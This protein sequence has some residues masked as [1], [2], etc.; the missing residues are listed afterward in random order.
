[1]KNHNKNLLFLLFAVLFMVSINSAIFYYTVCTGDSVKSVDCYGQ[2]Y[3]SEKSVN[4]QI[5]KIFEEYGNNYS[6]MKS[7]L[8]D[9]SN[10]LGDIGYYLRSIENN[11]ATLGE[12]R[13]N[14]NLSKER[15]EMLEKLISYFGDENINIESAKQTVSNRTSVLYLATANIDKYSDYNSFLATVSDNADFMLDISIYKNDLFAVNNIEKTKSDYALL[16]GLSPKYADDSGVSSFLN[17]RITDIIALLSIILLMPFFAGMIKSAGSTLTLDK[18]HALLLP[19]LLTGAVAVMQCA[20]LL[21]A[22]L[23]IG[24]IDF[25]L[26]IQSYPILFHSGE[27]ISTGLLILFF[28][29]SK[30]IGIAIFLL[31]VSSLVCVIKGGKGAKRIAGSAAIIAFVMLEA[32]TVLFVG[33]GNILKEINIF[34]AFSPE[35]FFIRYINL[36]IFGNAV[37]RIVVFIGFSLITFA[38]V[39]FVF[40]RSLGSFMKRATADAEQ[41]YYDEI[42]RKYE[43]SRAIRHDINNH[44]T[45]ISSFIEKGDSKGALKYI[46]EVFDQTSLAMQP[47]KTGSSVLDALLHKKTEQAKKSGITLSYEV[48]ASLNVGISDYDMCVVFG[49][50]LDNAIEA[51]KKADEDKRNITLTVGTQHDMLYI[52]CHNFHSNDIKEQ[53]DRLMTTKSDTS[54]HGIGLS[55]IKTV[56]AKYGGTVKVSYDEANFMIEVLIHKI[57]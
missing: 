5:N 54:M 3:E 55:R 2:S 27:R 18:R 36:D 15:E 57:K 30:I 7:E 32:V 43:Q 45:V 40:V 47:L 50:I 49:N 41:N 12:V 37:S 10:K 23:F 26:P 25:S 48:N 33:D 14:G 44:L 31:L 28:F 42:N 22:H 53:G 38:I 13:K 21:F 20:N 4:E 8:Q 17:Y 56:A 46:N 16:E 35:R 34:S 52:S 1:M 9:E 51:A 29:A 6:L 39:L 19:L 24:K 11:G